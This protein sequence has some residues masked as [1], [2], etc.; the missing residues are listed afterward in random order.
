MSQ[1]LVSDEVRRSASEDP[2]A[3]VA[4]HTGAKVT[5]LPLCDVGTETT[6]WL[7]ENERAGE[8]MLFTEPGLAAYATKLETIYA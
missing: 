6:G 8:R 4:R 2:A 5:R 1:G 3:A 7:V